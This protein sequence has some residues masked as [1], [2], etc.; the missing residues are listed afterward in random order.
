MNVVVVHSHPSPDSFNHTLFV[1]VVDALTAGGH[2]VDAMDLY[3]DGFQPAMTAA[4][5]HAYHGDNPIVDP[6]VQRYA[7]AVDRADALVF[8]YPTWWSGLP[9]AAK[10]WLEKVMVPGVAFGFD[11][12]SGKV[13]PRLQHVRRI[14]AVTTYGSPK[15]SVRL[16]ND[17]GR[18]T[19]LRALRVSTGFRTRT[20]WLGLYAVDQSTPEQREAFVAAVGREFRSW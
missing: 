12:R 7:D 10:G 2:H 5:R 9:A 19:L 13:K 11:E 14:A 8:V 6:L 17:N 16:V 20:T 1:T 15:R 4:E 18:R 3:A